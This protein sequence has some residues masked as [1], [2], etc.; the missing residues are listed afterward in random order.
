M[1]YFLIIASLAIASADYMF[2]YDAPRTPA[3][4]TKDI[5]NA[6]STGGP[7]TY[8]QTAHRFSGT[9]YDGTT[10]DTT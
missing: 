6:T 7:Y 2:S 5:L 9:A 4:D 3:T 8:S 1:F 10:I